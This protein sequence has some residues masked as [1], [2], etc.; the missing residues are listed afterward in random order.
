MLQLWLQATK[1]S[2]RDKLALRPIDRP[3]DPIFEE[4]VAKLGLLGPELVEQIALVYGQIRGY[5]VSLEILSKQH[6]DMNDHEFSSRAQG[7]QLLLTMAVKN[8]APLI[9][10]LRQRAHLMWKFR[11]FSKAAHVLHTTSG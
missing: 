1:N 6:A 10:N 5:R 4:M 7:A 3:T 8:G 2:E 9:D 11:P